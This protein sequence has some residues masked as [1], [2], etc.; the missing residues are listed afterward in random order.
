MH[1]ATLIIMVP[2]PR[3]L[4]SPAGVT[5][6]TPVDQAYK[7]GDGISRPPHRPRHQHHRDPSQRA[8]LTRFTA[9]ALYDPE[10]P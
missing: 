2:A 8:T 4:L 1:G 3:G 7:S 5:T 9:G 10:F 6:V